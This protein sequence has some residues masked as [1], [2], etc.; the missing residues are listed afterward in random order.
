[1]LAPQ[2]YLKMVSAVKSK[3]LKEPF[4]P[5]EAVRACRIKNSES[6]RKAPSR[7]RKGNP[8]GN[9]VLFVRLKDG[10]YKLTRPFKTN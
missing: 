6:F 5:H 3:R 9:P 8:Y 4:F 1:M 10:R 7:Y 2:T